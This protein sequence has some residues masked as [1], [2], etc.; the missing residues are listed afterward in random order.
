MSDEAV[1]AADQLQAELNHAQT[2]VNRLR[3]TAAPD[4]AATLDE[5]RAALEALA[6]ARARESCDAEALRQFNYD[7][8]QH[9]CHD[10]LHPMTFTKGYT[11]LL[12]D[13]TLGP[14]TEDQAEA[15]RIMAQKTEMMRDVVE[16]YAAFLAVSISQA[17]PGLARVALRDLIALVREEVARQ[18]RKSACD[19]TFDAPDDLPDVRANPSQLVQVVA[20]L[21]TNA[22]KYVPC[23]GAIT[24]RAERVAGG[25]R[26]A[27]S[28][29][30]VD[31]TNRAAKARFTLAR[32]FVQ[33]MGGAF[34]VESDAVGSAIT[35]TLLE[36]G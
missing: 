21:V 31:L 26:I 29:G 35:V 1:P 34:E 17:G 14:V 36:M 7:Q 13:G 19:L 4:Q 24:V 28:P 23:A 11:G 16:A 32:E 3:E 15:L 12:L 27:V 6:A 2:L 22:C 8:L 30:K 18:N 20:S 33:R 9:F 5:L 25:V 10:V